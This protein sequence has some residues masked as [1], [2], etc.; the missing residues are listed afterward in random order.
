MKNCKDCGKEITEKTA[1]RYP[2]RKSLMN[3]CKNCLVA[4]NKKNR[5]ANKEHYRKYYKE[6]YYNRPISKKQAWSKLRQAIDRGEVT[7]KPCAICGS[8]KNIEAHHFNY[9]KPLEVVW[10]CKKHHKE[11]HRK[12]L[13]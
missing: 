5:N 11:T 12:L 8:S 4:L 1:Y 6:Y 7:K 2:R 3:I 13:K 10:L 9:E